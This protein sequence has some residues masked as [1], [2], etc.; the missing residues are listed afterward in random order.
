MRQPTDTDILN[1][2]ESH[3]AL[4]NRPLRYGPHV[5]VHDKV[6]GIISGDDVRHY[7]G[8]TYRDA[9]CNAM[10]GESLRGEN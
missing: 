7:Y 10:Q 4:V 8:A 3:G 1:W 9:V 5:S 6:D 2:L